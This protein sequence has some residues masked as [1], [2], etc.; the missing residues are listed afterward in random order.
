[1]R[2]TILGAELWPDR[3]FNI[4]IGYNFRR[5]EEL[6]ILDQRNFSGLS[7]GVGIKNE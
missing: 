3:G 2:H 6:R 4:R 5:A 1:M 7:F